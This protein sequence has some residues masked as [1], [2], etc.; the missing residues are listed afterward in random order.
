MKINLLIK[1]PFSGYKIRMQIN[2][3]NVCKYT[4][5]RMQDLTDGHY[6]VD[7]PVPRAKKTSADDPG[8]RGRRSFR[9]WRL[10]ER[11]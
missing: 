5:K 2:L 11:P 6:F 8:S 4:G 7:Y 10:S 1:P 9:R 3:E